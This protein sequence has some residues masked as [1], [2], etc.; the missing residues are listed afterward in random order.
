MSAT[1]FENLGGSR[2][3]D[4]LSGDAGDNALFGELGNDSLSGGDGDDTLFGDAGLHVDT[5]DTG[6]SG[7]IAVIDG[8]EAEGGADTLVGGAG[9]DVLHGGGGD[10]YL[11]GGAGNDLLDGGSGNDFMVGG[12][13]DDVYV[14]NQGDGFFENAGEGT[15]EVRTASDWGLQDNIENLT[16]TG[17]GN[18]YLGGNALDNLLT[19]NSG[20]NYMVGEGGNDALDGGDG[21]DVAAYRLPAGTTG[22]LRTVALSDGSFLVQLVQADG[23][24]ED[25]FAVTPLARASATVTGIGS[26]AGLGTDTVT[27]AEDLHFYVDNWPAP[28]GEGQFVNLLLDV[29][30]MP[31]QDGFAHVEGSVLDDVIDV[32]ALYPEAGSDVNINVHGGF[33]DDTVFGSA[34][35]NYMRGQAGNDTLYGAAGDDGLSGDEGD[36][37]LH[38]GDGNDGLQGNDGDDILSGDAGNDSLEGGAGND[39]LT[40]GNGSD[41]IVGGNGSDVIDGGSDGDFAVFRLPTGTMG[42][43]RVVQGPGTM[44][45]VQLVQS[46]GSFQNVFEVAV[47]EDGSATVT[48]VGMMADSGTDSVRNVESLQFLPEGPFNPAQFTQVQI[49]TGSDAADFINGGGN[50]DVVV[51]GAGNDGLT[52]GGGDDILFGQGGDDP[53]IQGGAGNDVVSGGDGH[54]FVSGQGGNDRIFGDAGDD[55][56][57]GNAG[58]DYI[59]GGDGHDRTGYYHVNPALG[60]ATVSLLLQGQWQNTT[61]GGSDFLVNI[62][63]VSGSPFADTLIGDDVG[64]WLWGS[65]SFYD[66]GTGNIQSATNNDTIL[67]GGGDDYVQVGAGNHLLDGGAG[68]DW[69]AF[70][71]N[72]LETVGVTVSLALQDQPQDT[73]VGTWTIGGFENVDGSSVDDH[74]TGDDAA[75]ILG[76]GAG[77]DTLVGGGGN[78]RLLGDGGAELDSTG[79]SGSV[80]TVDDYGTVTG[81]DVL[82]G[83]EGND[84]LDGG[85]GNDLLDGGSGGDLMVG[86]AGDDV[87]VIDQAGDAMNPGDGVIEAA[88]DGTDEIRTCIDWG[89]VGIPMSRTSPRSARATSS[90]AAT[91]AT[92]C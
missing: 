71:E 39:S 87:Y 30:P 77:N 81:N 56:V 20:N 54:D 40:G 7:P 15:D 13:G 80:V 64:N 89:L 32:A 28:T 75:N 76:G 57:Q 60:G 17:S 45:L 36:D 37:A 21:R 82:M 65:S 61:V 73:G 22:M 25:V 16:A 24:F 31:L 42:S 70:N 55:Y 85:A 78:D 23:S 4:T 12:E 38:G 92:M 3:D 59:D 11:E 5:N 74:I 26:M 53:F 72:G 48:G 83:G 63:A 9:N 41:Y 33:G 14:I 6:R 88:G 51:G 79:Y 67:G 62:E 49:R 66:P 47:A 10:D 46:D 43:L 2:H 69:L 84:H 91:K 27:N 29:V 19:G 44:L 52:G 18:T 86:G 58:N 90:L 8:N 68:T 34:G 50:S 1:G 35:P